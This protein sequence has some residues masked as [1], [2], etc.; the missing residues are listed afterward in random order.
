MRKEQ[1]ARIEADKNRIYE[2]L[3]LE[4]LL[5]CI[6]PETRQYFLE[7]SNGATVRLRKF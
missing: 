6:N 4:K 7:G 1:A 5:S 3:K 2:I